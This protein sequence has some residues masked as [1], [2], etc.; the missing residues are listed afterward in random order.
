MEAAGDVVTAEAAAWLARL[1]G[2]ARTPAA[3]SAF[4]DWLAADAAHARAFARVTDVWDVL[5]GA[6]TYGQA[7]ARPR[8]ARAIS[9]LVAASLAVLVIG[10]GLAGYLMRHPSYRTEMGE[11]RT[12]ALADGTR[13]TL[14]TDSRLVVDYRP[15]ERIVRLTRGEALFE[16]A[17]NPAR[18]FIV[19]AGDEQVRALGTTFEVRTDHAKVAV[20]LIEGR[21]EVSKH[22][23]G[24]ASVRVAVLSPGERVVV[25]PDAPTSPAAIDRPKVEAVTAWRRGEVMF[26]DVSLADAI[27][28]LNRY[29]DS[30]IVVADPAL[31]AIRVSGVF[32]T[33]DPAEFA[34]AMAQLYG[35]RV[36]H[37]GDQI[38]LAK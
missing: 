12:V 20:T 22:P 25:R 3:E 14:N 21:V 33:H 18:P 6:A 35:L 32:E 38:A 5:P 34:D 24:A 31:A 26:D 17:K 36:E 2:P 29:G 10:G 8:P 11:Q 7:K 13:V 30:H 1:Q 4:K 15:G 37:D 28:E 9:V 16:V 23:P 27:T 19:Q